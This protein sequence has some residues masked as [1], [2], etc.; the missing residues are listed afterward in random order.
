MP[1]GLSDNLL[2]RFIAAIVLLP[3]VIFIIIQGGYWLTGLLAVGGVLMFLEWCKVT[4][5]PEIPFRIS[6]CFFVLAAV[7][8]GH[9]LAGSREISNLILVI[10]LPMLLIILSIRD[11]DGSEGR[12]LHI[13]RWGGNGVLYVILPLI[14]LA[15][16]RGL[17]DGA[18]YVFWTFLI[19]WATDIGGYFFGK[20]I[21]GPKLAPK[22]SPNKTWAGLLG[23][24]FLAAV[25]SVVL[26][27]ALDW[28][29]MQ[30]MIELS[31]LVAVIA[32]LG[33]LLES[34]VKRVFCVKDSGGI[35]PGHGGILDRIDGLVL[36]APAMVLAVDYFAIV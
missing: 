14:S 27:W 15:W 28:G 21:G 24:M 3:P 4:Q 20:A 29:H 26:S 25:A 13:L 19:V 17:E 5:I 16:L 12:G 7:L 31:L 2:K 36:A 8:L 6:G 32:Q 30:S 34:A 33:D 22:I 11:Y 1:L 10:M 35:I 9:I 18:I 23:G